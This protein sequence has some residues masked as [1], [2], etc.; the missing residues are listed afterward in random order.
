MSSLELS[1]NNITA[2]VLAGGKGSRLNGQDKP[3]IHLLDK[4]IIDHICETLAPQVAEIIVSCS[5]NV[6]IYE[7][8][9][10]RLAVDEEL[11]LGPLAGMT[12]AFS[13][14]TTEWVLT[15]PG[16]TPFIQPDIVSRLSNDAQQTGVAVP[17]VGGVKQ[18]LCLLINKKR[19]NQVC[20]FHATG[21]NAIKY[22][23]EDEEIAGT[24]MDDI[25]SSFLNINTQ[26]ELEEAR[27]RLVV[28]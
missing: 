1:P 21:G 7:L 2:V 23:L 5:R 27:H 14:V 17:L 16:D 8:M 15:T 19:R 22:W 24:D 28:H 6:A 11:N 13:L 3:L 25:A 9:T 26:A 4:R 12:K 20:E 18:N 10:Y